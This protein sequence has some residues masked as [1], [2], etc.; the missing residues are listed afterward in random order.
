MRKIQKILTTLLLTIITLP[1]M[2]QGDDFGMWYSI[3]A[4]KSFNKKWSLDGGIEFRNRNDLQTADRW[5]VGVGT[6]YKIVKG[7]KASVGYDF[8][9]S[10]NQEKITFHNDG[11][12]N[13][14]TPSYWSAR[15]RFGASISGSKNF[16]RV[17]VQLRERWQ[18]TYRPEVSGKKYD[19]DEFNPTTGTWN[20]DPEAVKEKG[21]NVLRSRLQVSYDFS[22][23]K[24]SPFVSVELFNAWNI[25]KVRYNAGLEYKLKKKH[26]FELS[27]R[28]QRVTDDEDEENC[29]LIGLGYTYK[30]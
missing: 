12:V 22:K 9:S 13:K 21:K 6:T 8:L 11:T 17:G 10:N 25:E 3:G 2:A 15:H 29:H 14:W 30:L 24:L 28:Y 19:L 18:Y 4:E 20:S 5:K 23:V 16:G 7:L 27:Y 1:A 26:V